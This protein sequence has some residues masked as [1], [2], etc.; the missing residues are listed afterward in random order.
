MNFMFLQQEQYLT[1]S[2]FKLTSNFLFIIWTIKVEI[3]K[4]ILI[5][6]LCIDENK[7]GRKTR[8]ES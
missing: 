8:W 2:C 5:K 6:I 1:C 4:Q 3:E 7:K